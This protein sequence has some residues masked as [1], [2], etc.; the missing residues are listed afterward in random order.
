[1][2]LVMFANVAFGFF[3]KGIVIL[4]LRPFNDHVMFL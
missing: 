4:Y 1:M 3:A 2:T